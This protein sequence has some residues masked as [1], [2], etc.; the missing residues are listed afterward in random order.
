MKISSTEEYGLRCLLRV[1]RS[2]GQ[3]PVSAQAVADGE[4][5]SL[6]YTQKLLRILTQSELIEARRGAQG[7]YVLSR[8]PSQIFLGDA[9]RAFGGM[10]ELDHIC[11]SHTG[12]NQQC[13][14]A[15]NCSLRP[16]WSYLSEFVVRTF[17]SIP[18]SLLMYQ[19]ERVA[20]MLLEHL[21]KRL[22][23]PTPMQCPAEQMA[24]AKDELGA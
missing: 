11:E 18:L 13:S 22:E 4:G 8:D 21:P 16:V 24:K 12:N 7:G 10:I 14:N 23:V 5:L 15:Q 1:G 6:P 19:E 9:I 17:D 20:S 2:H 3:D